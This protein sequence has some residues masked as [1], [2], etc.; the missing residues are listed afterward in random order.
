MNAISYDTNVFSA[1][2]TAGLIP[3]TYQ[4]TFQVRVANTPANCSFVYQGATSGVS[5]AYVSVP[6]TTGC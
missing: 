6:T 3:D 4:V 5:S 2:A 1:S